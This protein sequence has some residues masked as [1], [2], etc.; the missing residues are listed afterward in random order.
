MPSDLPRL[1]ETAW[2][3]WE[4]GIYNG[5]PEAIEALDRLLATMG[6]QRFRAPPSKQRIE[7]LRLFAHGATT[8]TAAETMGVSPETVR[9]LLARVRMQLGARTTI[10]AVAIAWRR[11]LI[12]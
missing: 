10:Q 4:A 5:E 3:R 2:L 12:E 6:S 1:A 7:V 9:S 11:G 8:R